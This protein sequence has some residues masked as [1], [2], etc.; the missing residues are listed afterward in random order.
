[1]GRRGVCATLAMR[2]HPGRADRGA[3][4]SAVDARGKWVDLQGS[5]VSISGNVCADN[6]AIVEGGGKRRRAY[7]PDVSTDGNGCLVI[8][9]RVND[10]G[11]VGAD[12]GKERDLKG[13]GGSFIVARVSL[14]GELAPITVAN[15]DDDIAMDAVH[16]AIRATDIAS[17]R[18]ATARDDA[19]I[20][21][22]RNFGGVVGASVARV[23][24]VAAIDIASSAVCR[25]SAADAASSY[26]RE[27]DN[28]AG[29]NDCL[30]RVNR[31]VARDSAL[32]AT[33]SIS[34]AKVALRFA[35]DVVSL[36][37]AAASLA[38]E[39][40][41][42]ARVPPP[43]AAVTPPSLEPRQMH[44]VPLAPPRDERSNV[45]R[46]WPAARLVAELAAEHAP[47]PDLV[48]LDPWLDPVRS[49]GRH[50]EFYELGVARARAE[51]LVEV[52]DVA[53]EGCDEP[54][55][56]VGL[57]V[58]DRLD[59]PVRGHRKKEGEG[60]AGVV[61][62]DRVPEHACTGLE[63]VALA[64]AVARLWESGRINGRG[65][66]VGGVGGGVMIA[67]AER[68]GEGWKRGD[69]EAAAVPRRRVSVRTTGACKGGQEQ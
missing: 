12:C 9:A 42:V 26:A 67:R 69:G 5:R 35:R 10:S 16:V 17:A 32:L 36:A 58:R 40:T 22:R 2:D 23:S 64:W 27:G 50:L 54:A 8:L 28:F 25:Q 68:G 19:N 37:N 15:V 14:D 18:P 6:V 57:G 41:R 45:H 59:L 55:L 24:A 11:K 33:V 46:G 34:V 62:H 1:M 13:S 29:V 48:P 49:L 52:V 3:I 21:T 66:G 44:H 38:A 4:G 47:V 20:A 51:R 31:S 63:G 65:V 61:L 39:A 7:A 43:T 30:A 53:L 56:P 60:E